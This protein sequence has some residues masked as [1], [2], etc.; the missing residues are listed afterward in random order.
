MSPMG[1]KM[2]LSVEPFVSTTISPD[3]LVTLGGHIDY[4]AVM[5]NPNSAGALLMCS[6]LF[7]LIIYLQIFSWLTQSL[8]RLRNRS[9]RFLSR[10][11]RQSKFR[12]WN[13]SLKRYL[14]CMLAQDTLGE[15]FVS[16]VFWSI[17]L[18]DFCRKSIIRGALTNGQ[19]WIFL[20]LKMNSGGN[21]ATYSQSKRLS[22]LVPGRYG[23]KE[24]SRTMCNTIAGII[25]YWASGLSLCKCYFS[26]WCTSGD[27]V[28]RLN[29]ATKTLGEMIGSSKQIM[30]DCTS[31]YIM[32]IWFFFSHI[33]KLAPGSD[34]DAVITWTF[35]YFSGILRLSTNT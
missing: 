25:E 26:Y 33:D 5:A 15:L 6:T 4:T 32:L 1:K 29:I 20:I 28:N 31:S 35:R 13:M 8:R 9:I 11:P 21:G 30:V 17:K 19:V 27:V 12:S 7:G 2:V 24:V 16:I 18:L 23:D 3:S 14:K 22:P 34:F 10:K